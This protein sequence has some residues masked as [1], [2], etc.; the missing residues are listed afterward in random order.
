M[1]KFALTLTAAALVLGINALTANAQT[2]AQGAGNLHA[3]IQNATPIVKPVA[4][5]G[6]GAHCPA[7]FVQR[8]GFPHEPHCRCVRC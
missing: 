7:G 5:R 4:C 3:Q 8:C 2:Q 6:M 1:K